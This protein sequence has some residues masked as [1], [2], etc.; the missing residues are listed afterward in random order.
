ML[1]RNTLLLY[2]RR[3]I[4]RLFYIDN[5][6]VVTSL[7]CTEVDA[8]N[9]QSDLV[10]NSMIVPVWV[11]SRMDSSKEILCYCILDDQ[12]NA[13]FIYRISYDSN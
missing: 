7:K 12:S 2:F 1:K 10:D 11:R 3:S 13:C 4:K 9:N 8:Y 6:D 5:N